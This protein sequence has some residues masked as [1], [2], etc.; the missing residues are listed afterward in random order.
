MPPTT[1][2]NHQQSP[3]RQ[4][5]SVLALTDLQRRL[6][7]VLSKLPIGEAE[8][9]ALL[10][11]DPLALAR[12]M[13][14]ANTPVFKQSTDLP[15]AGGIVASL[16]PTLSQR[17][18]QQQPI[19]TEQSHELKQ[20]WHHA[21]ATAHAAKELAIRTGL[22]DPEFAYLVGLL[23]DLPEWLLRLNQLSSEHAVANCQPTESLRNCQLPK[24]FVSLLIAIHSKDQPTSTQHPPDAAGLIRA[25]ELLAEIAGFHHPSKNEHELLNEIDRDLDRDELLFAK[26]LQRLV[27]QSLRS[28]GFDPEIT[29]NEIAAD[30]CAP[31]AK[32]VHN[33]LE[34]AVTNIKNCTN[35]NN[36]RSIIT[37]LTA[38]S[39]RHG[40]Y[41][42]AI[43]AKWQN[44]SGTLVLRA[45]ADSSSRRV[46]HNRIKVS[47]DEAEVLRTALKTKTTKH[48]K[49]N[50][51]PTSGLLQ[52]LSSDELLVIPLNC[53]FQTPAFLILD[54]SITMAPIT[55][56][57][58]ITMSTMLGM[59]G[60]LMIENLL[61][62]RQRERAQKCAMTDPLTHLFNRRMG[63]L[64]L[65]QLVASS[66]RDQR[67]LTILMC[68]LDHFKKLN[69]TFG[70]ASG[71]AAICATANV[72]RESVRKSDTVCR[73]GG[74]EFLVVLPDTT[75]DEA[76]VL[77]ARMF[78]AVRECG[79]ALDMPITISIGLTSHRK[80][81]TIESILRRA[82]HAL[83]ASKDFGRNRF[84]VDVECDEEADTAE[85]VSSKKT[86]SRSLTNSTFAQVI[87]KDKFKPI[88]IDKWGMALD[89]AH[90]GQNQ[91][92]KVQ[93]PDFRSGRKPKQ[94]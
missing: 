36:Y 30:D 85:A 42:S 81:D 48:L 94:P 77:A 67:P 40:N 88:T 41:D 70:H 21:I 56:A 51:S 52:M 26:Q 39:V 72:L 76:I 14:A 7:R 13:R 92:S 84:S 19:E 25:A 2:L 22:L 34:E 18:F 12:G 43:Y 1:S 10:K 59:T 29:E 55:V 89:K 73:Y 23:H 27:G 24:P 5:P 71:D 79:E 63:I 90:K 83:Y 15:T 87:D 62:R 17:L 66:R 16:G 50:N 28:F 9:I 93:F 53:E 3:L 47:A 33:N 32:E 20:L 58:D 64:A 35:S 31:K 80:N 46:V 60:S 57:N 4:L 75:P 78:T 86:A 11:I 54:R 68:D 8:M 44:E 49:A 6:T 74:E 37:V 65:D 91:A 61:H 45:K 82:D 38:A 69:D